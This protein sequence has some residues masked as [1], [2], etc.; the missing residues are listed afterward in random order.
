MDTPVTPL[1]PETTDE[2]IIAGDVKEPTLLNDTDEGAALLTLIQEYDR[3]EEF[4]RGNLLMEWKKQI[5][6]WDGFSYL[7][8]DE[9]AHDWRTPQ[10]ISAEDPTNDIDPS[11][12][13]KVVNIYKAHGEILIGALSSGTPTV[14]FFPAD[15]DDHEDTQ[16]AKAYSKICELIQRH[17]RIRLFF[18]KALYILYN[19]GFVACYNESKQDFKYGYTEEPEYEDVPIIDRSLY[20]PACGESLSQEQLPA[21]SAS[22]PTEPM[23]CNNCGG[24]VQPEA[25]DMPSS[26]RQISD[27]SKI[28]KS[29]ECLEVYGPMNVKVPLWARDQASVPYLILETEEPITLMR[30]IYPELADKINDSSYPDTREKDAR[31]PVSY[32]GDWPRNLCTVQRVWLRP[33]ALN[34]YMRDQEL[35][36]TMKSTYKKGL[37]VV[38]INGSLAAEIVEDGLDEHWTISEQPLAETLHPRAIGATMVPLQ[39]IENEL[40]NITLETIEFGMGEVFADPNVLDFDSYGKVEAKPGQ[41]SAAVAPV[42]QGLS[43]GFYEVKPATLSREVDLFAERMNSRQQFVQGTYPSIYGGTLEGGGGTAREYET[44]KASALQR[45]STTWIILQE[46]YAQIMGKAT[47]SYVANMKGDEHVVQAQGSNFVNVWIRQSELGGKVGEVEPEVSEAFPVSWS[48]KRDILLNLMQ[49][50]NEDIS[51]VIRHP[52]N[53]STVA[54]LIGVPELYIP[55]DD[56]RNK[57]LYE[58]AQLIM[59]APIEGAPMMGFDA[60]KQPGQMMSSVPVTPELDDHEV[61]AEICRA[62]LRSEV[63]LDARTTNPPGYANVLAHLKEHLMYEAASQPPPDE[64]G[65]E[66]DTKKDSKSEE[67]SEQ[68]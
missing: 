24:T 25:E 63:G 43:A 59:N 44:S 40:D 50:G 39:D 41:I 11:I 38:V 6:Y 46:W 28:P 51:A 20:C 35:M 3:E 42:G 64:E 2:S 27:Y 31:V 22:Q 56:S 48:Q 37:Y 19:Q 4:A 68:M 61:E 23:Q 21:E 29:R 5:R 8:W 15:A 10:E 67:M 7:A 34:L 53:A 49:M 14:R 57:Q 1:G 16:T 18:M 45:L 32:R 12:N 60:M 55:G 33:W 47:K 17:N 66:G 62:W 52:E 36:K 13:A 30:E 26:V 65:A 58:I 9:V 54:R